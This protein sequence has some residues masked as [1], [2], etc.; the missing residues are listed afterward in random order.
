[1]PTTRRIK[2]ATDRY[3]VM[4]RGVGRSMIFEDDSDRELFLDTLRSTSHSGVQLHAWCLMDNHYHLLAEAK[5]DRL[6]KMLR[7]LNSTYALYFNERHDRIG[8]LFQGRFKSEP[9]E[10]DEYFLTVLRYIHQNP[11]R[12]GLAPSCDYE[13]SS[14]R[15]YMDTPRLCTNELAHKLLVDNRTFLEL[16]DNLSY[17]TLPLDID[18]LKRFQTNDRIIETAQKALPGIHIESIMGMDR[19]GRDDALR[20]LKQ[21][22]LSVRQ[23]ERLTGIS[24]SVIARA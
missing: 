21:T 14:F 6:S 11:L 23:I 18:G 8:H 7:A 16:H 9:I 15:G 2:S 19:K 24:R 4:A 13:W 3:H 17:D 20:K 1:M 12:G 10:S 5:L 22:R